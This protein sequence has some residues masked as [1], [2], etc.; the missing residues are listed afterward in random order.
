MSEAGSHSAYRENH[1]FGPEVVPLLLRDLQDNH[2]RW[3]A[4]LQAITGAQ[5]VAR[6]MAGNIPSMVEAWLRWAKKNG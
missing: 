1:W 3:F 5:P 2:T 4:A 6:D